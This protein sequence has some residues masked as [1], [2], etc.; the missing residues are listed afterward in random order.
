MAEFRNAFPVFVGYPKLASCTDFFVDAAG[1]IRT[2][3]IADTKVVRVVPKSV[4]F[5]E[6]LIPAGM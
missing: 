4:F 3:L 5:Q 6:I 1:I 2:F